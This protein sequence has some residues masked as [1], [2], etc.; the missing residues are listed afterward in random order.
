V[1]VRHG[2][3]AEV[4]PQ[5]R[6]DRFDA[7]VLAALLGGPRAAEVLG[8][9]L[10]CR[11]ILEVEAAGLAA[12]RAGEPELERLT[13]AVRR[14]RLTAEGARDNPAGEEL[15]RQ[16]DVAFHREVVHAAGNPVLGRMTEPIHRALSATFGAQARPHVRFE[17]GLPE[18]ERI[19]DAIRAG[20][21][22]EARTA[23]R[24]HLLT[25]EEHLGEYAR[26]RATPAAAG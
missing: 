18:H 23:M 4:A 14:M 1:A 15:Y 16:A 11:R 9:Y 8:E 17:R 12:E 24:D 3:G 26:R 10:E 13:E 20:S 19:L 5:D 6:W 22:E 7:D 25:V 2:R 21:A